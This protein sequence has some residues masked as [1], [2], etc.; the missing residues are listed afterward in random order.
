MSDMQDDGI[1]ATLKYRTAESGIGDADPRDALD[2]GT[3]SEGFVWVLTTNLT[4]ATLTLGVMTSAR[5]QGPGEYVESSQFAVTA[6]GVTSAY[7]TG[8]GRYV[9]LAWHA[10]NG[11]E[12]EVLYVRKG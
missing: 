3:K 1:T 12:F 5:N 9:T 4:T 6:T 7:L 11:A 2:I 8:L 10:G